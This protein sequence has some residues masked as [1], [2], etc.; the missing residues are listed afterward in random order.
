M[1]A[2]SAVL[3]DVICNMER[4]LSATDARSA[5]DGGGGIAALVRNCMTFSVVAFVVLLL[6]A[7]KDLWWPSLYD[8]TCASV[9][10]CNP[11]NCYC[12]GRTTSTCCPCW[13]P[14]FHEAV[15]LRIAIHEAWC[16]RDVDSYG[17]MNVFVLVTCGN[18]PAKTT[19]VRRVP[20]NNEQRPVVWSD[21]VDLQVAIA[22]EFVTLQVVDVDRAEAPEV[23]GSTALRVTDLLRMMTG[24]LDGE[25]LALEGVV[26]TLMYEGGDSGELHMSVYATRPGRALPPVLPGMLTHAAPLPEKEESMTKTLRTLFLS[27]ST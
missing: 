2:C 4:F 3:V 11:R 12:I 7:N 26:K 23:V 9:K 24:S 16:L 25:G 15:R 21:V 1:L 13:F 5:D 18:N 14:D 8:A 17:S 22:D 19:T 27:S 10:C 6:Y 20:S